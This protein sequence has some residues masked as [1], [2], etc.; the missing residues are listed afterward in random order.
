[1]LD[2]STR[3]QQAAF[4]AA[5]TA[6]PTNGFGDI[7]LPELFKGNAGLS[8]R[9]FAVYR[10]NVRAM[11]MRAIGN[12]FPIV[13]QITGDEFFEG[14]AREYAQRFDSENG[15]L[16]LYGDRFAGFVAGFEHTQA[17]PYLPDVA[18]MEWLLHRAYF[19]RDCAAF[20]LA[21]LA[22]VPAERHGELRFTFNPAAAILT[23]DY[24]LARIWEVHQKNFSDTQ[25]VDF[26]AGPHFALVY[27]DG[28]DGVV[29]KLDAGEY[30]FLQSLLAGT[31]LEVALTRALAQ[32]HQF[33]IAA[34]LRFSTARS[35]LTSL[36]W[37]PGLA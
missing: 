19:A 15:D 35:V 17:L 24:P 23:S 22:D 33:D 26:T 9:R 27:R 5:M 36:K 25:T 12:T 7:P 30:A 10:N 34:A 37:N 4:A 29:A 20:D 21:Q 18:R 11:R 31:N 6:A 1:M 3:A 28:F 16:N 32:N 2:G 13:R 14:L 8:A